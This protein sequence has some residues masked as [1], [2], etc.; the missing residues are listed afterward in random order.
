MESENGT[1]SC[2]I[3]IFY[4]E[5]VWKF[6]KAYFASVPKMKILFTNDILLIRALFLN[7]GGDH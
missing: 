4:N 6:F 1:R 7:V 2:L 3:T 5:L